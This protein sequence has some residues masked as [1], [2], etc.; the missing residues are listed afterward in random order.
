MSGGLNGAS[1][2]LKRYEAM[3][4][5][6]TEDFFRYLSVG[7][8][9]A[10]LYFCIISI[11]VE[12]FKFEGVGPVSIAYAFGVSFHFLANKF[13]TF[14]RTR[15]NSVREFGRYVG[16]ICLNYLIT[17]LFVYVVVDREG[18]PTYLGAALAI[19]ATTAIGYALTKL[20]VFQ[21]ARG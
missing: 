4:K 10:V 16:V 14:R 21:R 18:Y 1:K 2:W 3:K 20:W 12:I 13:Y 19:A 17:A 9:T 6:I 8:A 7:A 5:A 15:T 11:F